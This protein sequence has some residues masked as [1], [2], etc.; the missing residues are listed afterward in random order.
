PTF[1]ISPVRIHFWLV[2]I[3]LAGGVSSPVKYFFIGAIPAPMSN[4]DLSSLGTREKLGI[5]KC[6][7]SLKK[8]KNSFLISC[9]P[10]GFIST[11]LVFVDLLKNLL[12]C[13][14]D[15]KFYTFGL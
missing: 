3:R 15:L 14:E 8:S 6:S 7:F 12:F 13:R 11:P 2:A 5:I 4:N 10:I 9:K 1:S